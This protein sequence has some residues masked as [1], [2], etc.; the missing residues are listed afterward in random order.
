[1]MRPHPRGDHSS[2]SRIAP[3][4]KQ[5]TR[6]SRRPSC[7]RRVRAGP[8]LPSYLAL[9]HA[10]FSVPRVLPLERWALTPPFHPYQMR[11][12]RNRHALG[13]SASLP[14]RP[15]LTGGIFSVALSVAG[16]SNSGPLT[17]SGALPFALR[18]R[19]RRALESGLSSRLPS[20]RARELSASRRSPGSSAYTHYTV[21]SAGAAILLRLWTP[22]VVSQ[23]E[24]LTVGVSG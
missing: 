20:V 7:E 17:L 1:M 5:P 16:F 2:R 14:P 10:G 3:G 23:F 13:F 6:G 8:A 4:L 11:F 22:L 18:P 19:G 15:K 24:I 9:L 12:V 21:F